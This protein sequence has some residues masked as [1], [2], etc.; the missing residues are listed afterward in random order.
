MSPS[1]SH[2]SMTVATASL[3]GDPPSP[4]R[5]SRGPDSGKPLA[6]HEVY[7]APRHVDAPLEV[8]P[9]DMGPDPGARERE[10]PRLLLADIRG[11][12]Y[13]IAQLAVDLDDERDL[14]RGYAALV[15]G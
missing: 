15:P 3:V 11:G 5:Y 7:Q 8:S 14:L 2:R 13:A 4:R 1:S 12:L 10:L 9:L 6:H